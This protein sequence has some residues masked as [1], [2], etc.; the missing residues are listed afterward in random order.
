PFLDRPENWRYDPRSGRTYPVFDV[1]LSDR[2]PVDDPAFA[3][4]IRRAVRHEQVEVLEYLRRNGGRPEFVI[5]PSED[6]LPDQPVTELAPHQVARLSELPIATGD[7]REGLL[8]ALGLLDRD[9]LRAEQRLVNAWDR[10]AE[11]TTGE[12]RLKLV[13][14]LSERW[15]SG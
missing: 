3:E 14:E 4:I 1:R 12:Q 6:L 2:V 13:R 8:D 7:G 15:V 9:P 10:L 11:F 5:E